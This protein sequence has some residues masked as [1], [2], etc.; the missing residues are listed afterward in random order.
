[1]MLFALP[2]FWMTFW[3]VS[4]HVSP[5]APGSWSDP[6]NRNTFAVFTCAA[7]LRTSRFG[8]ALAGT[9]LFGEMIAPVDTQ[10]FPAAGD[11][12]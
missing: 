12:M 1:M 4:P 10:I 8:Y 6:S 9:S 7:S 5:K 3:S 2:G 11:E